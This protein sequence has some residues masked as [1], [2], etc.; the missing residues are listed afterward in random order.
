MDQRPVIAIVVPTPGEFA[1][2]RTLLPDLRRIDGAGPWELYEAAIEGRRVVFAVSGAGPVN[3]A[4]A[5]ERLVMAYAPAAVLNGGS[6]GAH[7]PELLPGDLILG[8][9][10]V[11]HLARPAQE[12]RVA[13]GLQPS[14]IRFRRGGESVHLA[15]IEADAGLLAIAQT[16]A[17]RLVTEMG[18][19]RS[20]GWPEH[21]TRRNA[22]VE[23]GTIASA[24]VWTVDGEELRQLRED[25][26]A[27]CEDMESAY[28]A[29]VCTMHELPFMAVRVVSNNEVACQIAPR[30]IGAAITE[31]GARAAL[32]LLAIAAKA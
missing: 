3:A 21:V 12:A 19:W 1:P 9:R 29:Q 5:T 7:N 32:V 28:V 20:A 26:G 11:V 13:R 18:L 27:E 8:E 15:Q 23:S 30:E 2:Y 25:F 31:A 16:A 14:L 6:A 24:D 4:A 22:R 17:E 10:Y